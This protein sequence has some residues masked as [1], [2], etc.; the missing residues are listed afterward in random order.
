MAGQRLVNAGKRKPVRLALVM[1]GFLGLLAA[2]G[3]GFFWW[4]VGRGLTEARQHV[5][6]GR[7]AQARQSVQR[8]RWLHPADA[9]GLLLLAEALIKDEQLAPEQ[10]A[11]EALAVLD[12]ISD[13]APQAADAY[14]QKG[15]ILLFLQHRPGR[16]EE[17]FRR[18]IELDP[19][20][21]EP[22]YLLYKLM[23]LTGRSNL[24]ESL[25]WRVFE[26]SSD[27]EKP[28]RLREWYMSQFYPATANPTLDQLMGILGPEERPSVRTEYQRFLDFRNSEPDRGISWAALAR[29]FTLEGDPKFALNLLADAEPQLSEGERMAPFYLASKTAALIDLGL[30]EQV[31]Q[32]FAQWPEPHEGYEYWK[33]RAIIHDEVRSDHEAAVTA[34]RE[35]LAVWPGPADWRTR[36]RLANCLARL[37][38]HDEAEQQR[39]TARGVEE[40]MDEQRHAQVRAALG[41][42]QDPQALMVVA[43][44]YRDLGRS[45][46]AASW[47]QLSQR[48]RLLSGPGNASDFGP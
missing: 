38:R 25:F 23:D 8:Y 6:N 45:R 40:L 4:Y 18:A 43:E 29:W 9:R 48:A 30:F 13:A 34:Y 22:H 17:A 41:R 37:G 1:L 32:V 44:F 35:A 42:L 16:A 27:E 21:A 31:E 33:W 11:G 39:S 12:Q 47:L 14:T 28:V 7:W 10:A 5:A 2:G 19:R 26:L 15:R 36:F 46:E 20:A 3:G 24:S